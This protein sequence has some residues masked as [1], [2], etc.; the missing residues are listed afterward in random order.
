LG[1]NIVIF[2]PSHQFNIARFFSLADPF[3]PKT[4]NHLLGFFCIVLVPSPLQDGRLL[5][6]CVGGSTARPLEVGL[7]K[8]RRPDHLTETAFHSSEQFKK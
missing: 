6:A 2:T 4:P 5:I 1:H 8:V 7:L 3:Y